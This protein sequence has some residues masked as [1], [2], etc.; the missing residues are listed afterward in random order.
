MK[1]L[2][3]ID[4]NVIVS[5]I[6]SKN[7]AP[8]I[9]LKSML[10]AKFSYL[11]SLELINEYKRVLLRG[12]I[13][14]RHGLTTNEILNILADITENGIIQSLTNI[15]LEVPHK[16]DNHLWQLLFSQPNTIL[17]TGDQLLLKRPPEFATVMLPKDFLFTASLLSM[18]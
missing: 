1:R 7:S 10:Q 15:S 9:V 17:V 12:K 8:Y 11:L 16:N 4:T 3:V 18:L 14:Q 13:Q 5:G 6:L 2:P